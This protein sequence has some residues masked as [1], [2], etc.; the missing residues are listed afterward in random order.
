MGRLY[1]I[2]FFGEA[3]SCDMSSQTCSAEQNHS[4]GMCEMQMPDTENACECKDTFEYLNP[5]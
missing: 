5:T 1:D 2:S 4:C 3:E